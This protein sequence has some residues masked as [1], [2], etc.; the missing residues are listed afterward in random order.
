MMILLDNWIFWK[1]CLF[2][3][4]FIVKTR[5]NFIIKENKVPYSRNSLS[6]IFNTELKIKTKMLS[7]K[8][9]IRAYIPV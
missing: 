1:I 9:A 8:R 5:I 6:E 7:L 3:N 2:K 4:I